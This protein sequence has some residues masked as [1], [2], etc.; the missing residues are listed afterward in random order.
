MIIAG[1]DDV[2][3]FLLHHFRRVRIDQC[4]KLG[5]TAL[6][7]SAIQGRTRCA[8]LL[9][10]AGTR[11]FEPYERSSVTFSDRVRWERKAMVAAVR[12]SVRPSVCPFACFHSIF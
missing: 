10:F 6:M 5:F 7:K 11:R 3:S 2:V 4:N 1:H 12:P 9:L 8:K